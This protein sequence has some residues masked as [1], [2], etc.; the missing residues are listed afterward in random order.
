[1]CAQY[2]S[3]FSNLS[4]TP[5]RLLALIVALNLPMFSDAAE[6]FQC[7]NNKGKKI[8]TDD[9]RHCVDPAQNQASQADAITTVELK[10]QN[11]HSQYGQ[12]VSEEYHNYA[13]RS[14]RPIDGYTLTIIAEDK[15]AQESPELL[16]K[17]AKKLEHAVQSAI[18]LYPRHIQGEFKGIKYYIFSGA[19]ASTGG[20]RGGFWYFRRGNSV[21][22]R[23]DDS[24]VTRSAKEYLG[25]SE[26]AAIQ[27]AVHELAHAFYYYH[28][29]D[30]YG[31]N[32]QAFDNANSVNLYR[33][34]TSWNGRL[35]KKAYALT[36]EREYFAE[37][38]KT[39]LYMNHHQPNDR[40]A[41]RI[42]DPTGFAMIENALMLPR[43]QPGERTP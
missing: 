43:W 41:L 12:T 33:N 36:N 5:L 14:Y 40:E 10:P 23:F 7:L 26:K 18:A 6:I 16:A 22:E 29:R 19:E 3:R 39:Y 32:K 30:M 20:R 15:L 13:F 24:I 9:R 35:I 28:Y 34:L 21:S 42:Y 2:P 4:N 38:A 37:L 1:M 11:L 27:V 17:A 31:A 8:F 25:Y